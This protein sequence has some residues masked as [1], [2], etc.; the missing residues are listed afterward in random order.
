MTT[1][2]QDKATLRPPWLSK[3]AWPYQVRQIRV[4][5]ETVGYTDEGEGPTL[6]LVHDGMWSFIWGQLIGHLAQHFR[7]VTLD[8]PG[9]GLSPA[10]EGVTSLER[11]SQV[12]EGLVVA[13][14]LDRMTLIVHDLGGG[15]GIGMGGRRPQAVQALVLMNTFAW[16][17]QV[18]SLRTMLRVVGSGPIRGFNSATKA[19]FRLSAGSAGVGRHMTT[20][21]RRVFLAG[22][23]SR[24]ARERFHDLMKSAIDDELYLARVEQAL[25]TRL[26]HVPALTI[27]GEK[28]DP[29]GF[30]ARFGEILDD[31]EEMVVDGGNHFPMADDPGGVAERIIDWHRR[32][33]TGD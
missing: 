21:E 9:S 33:V 20:E 7:V 14:G 3:E 25:S 4:G 17:P 32:K 10:S 29:F 1:E 16:P 8:F 12:L 18:G 30:Q 6:L 23:A 22:F 5:Q 19:I 24:P 28:N 2:S 15:V 11:D 13:L 26:A 27:F 31:V